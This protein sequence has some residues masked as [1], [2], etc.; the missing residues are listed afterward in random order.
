MTV[1]R[2]SFCTGSASLALG[3]LAATLGDGG[4]A[5]AHLEEAVRRND[6]LGAVVYAAA[7]RGA[8]EGLRG[9]RPRGGRGASHR[10]PPAPLTLSREGLTM[11]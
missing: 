9:G 10:A 4:A 11:A 6:A 1:G 8:L 7:A 5:A 3:L 2:G